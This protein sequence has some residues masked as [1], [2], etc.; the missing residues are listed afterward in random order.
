MQFEL[1]LGFLL[2]VQL[3]KIYNSIVV[4][5]AKYVKLYND[6]KNM[7][8]SVQTEEVAVHDGIFN[9]E[10]ESPITAGKIAGIRNGV[11]YWTSSISDYEE[12]TDGTSTWNIGITSWVV[13]NLSLTSDG[14]MVLYQLQTPGLSNTLRF[15]LYDTSFVATAVDTTITGINAIRSC[16]LVVGYDG[17]SVYCSGDGNFEDYESYPDHTS[18]R[19]VYYAVAVV[20]L[21]TGSITYEDNKLGIIWGSDFYPVDDMFIYTPK[22]IY[23]P[24]LSGCLN[25]PSPYFSHR[26]GLLNCNVGGGVYGIGYR[27]MYFDGTYLYRVLD[28]TKS[29]LQKQIL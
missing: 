10:C 23:A 13:R 11:I 16:R 6:I 7:L 8:S 15:K 19:E 21:T 24:F 29:I 22:P 14:W 28:G 5:Y 1:I 4:L 12:I 17:T 18:N 20:N 9:M 25:S 27:N 2:L 3:T 26:N